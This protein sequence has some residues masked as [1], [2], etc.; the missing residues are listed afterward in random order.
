MTKEEQ[1][2][3]DQILLDQIE[4]SRAAEPL[5]KLLCRKHHPHVTV[6]VT[7]TSIELMEGI[8]TI[9]KIYDYLTD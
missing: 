4:L 2:Q 9:P 7:G 3:R 1:Q 6:I 8:M 5:I